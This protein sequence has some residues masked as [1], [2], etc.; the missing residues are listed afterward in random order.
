MFEIVN[1]VFF[2]YLVIVG[3]YKIVEGKSLAP[4]SNGEKNISE[5]CTTSECHS[6]SSILREGMNDTVNPCEDFYSYV[7][8]SWPTKYPVPEDK[9]KLDVN[10]M[11]GEDINLILKKILE[12]PSSPEDSVPLTLEKKW[13]KSC[14]DEVR[15]DE[16]GLEPLTNILEEIGGWPMAMNKSAWENKKITWQD[17]AQ[18]YAEIIGGYSLFDISIQPDLDNSTRQIIVIDEPEDSLIIK[19]MFD[20]KA[21]SFSYEKII[22]FNSNSDNANIDRNG[23]VFKYMRLLINVARN[24]SKSILGGTKENIV[25][26]AFNLI[27]F[28]QS[29]KAIQTTPDIKVHMDLVNSKMRIKDFQLYTDRKNYT[30]QRAKIDWLQMIRALFVNTNIVIRASKKVALFDTMYIDSLIELLNR[31]PERTIVNYIHWTFIIDVLKYLDKTTR[32]WLTDMTNSAMGIIKE[33]ERWEVCL[34]DMPLK[35]GMTIEYIKNHF[36]NV[37]EKTAKDMAEEIRKEIDKDISRSTWMNSETKMLT[38]NKLNSMNVQIGYP[39][40][41][42]SSSNF[43]QH[44]DGLQVGPDYF[45]NAMNYFKFISRNYTKDFRKPY[46]KKRWLMSPI[47]ANAYY[48]SSTN[49]IAAQLS[50]PMFSEELPLALNYGSVGFIIGHEMSHGFDG[51]GRKYNINGNRIPWW[52]DEMIYK[53]TKKAECFETQFYNYKV[54][55][56]QTRDENIADTLGL[57]AAYGAYKEK[58]TK[59]NIKYQSLPGFENFDSNKMFFVSYGFASCLSATPQFL[60]KLKTDEHSKPS[61]RINGALANVDGFSEAFNCPKEENKCRLWS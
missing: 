53:Y 27:T 10:S 21:N 28:Q 58:M 55:G 13:F 41:Y 46:D 59:D 38:R 45:E 9:F 3:S 54:N 12:K 2:G 20:N 30:K 1:L 57:M 19:R 40:W 48:L 34:N 24:Y 8:G 6:L 17:V 61:I 56:K 44:Y 33:S 60:K 42:L 15:I 29:L 35:D 11:M 39:E 26:D 18:Y 37:T 7:C 16:K 43:S 49:T 52:S 47:M 36:S 31:T 32:D 22:S 14:M 23:P 4:E 51:S 50:T 25:D 5:I